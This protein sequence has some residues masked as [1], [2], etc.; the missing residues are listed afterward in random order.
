MLQKS[1]ASRPRPD[2]HDSKEPQYLEVFQA[3]EQADQ[4]NMQD[5]PAYS[6]PSEQVK[7]QD[8]PAYCEQVKLQDNPA[9][10]EQV[11]LL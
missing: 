9:Y 1:P 10:C 3:T 6:V 8:N 4:I 2:K 11:I 7:L 5:N